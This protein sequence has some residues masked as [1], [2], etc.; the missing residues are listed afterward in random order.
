VR[1]SAPPVVFSAGWRRYSGTTRSLSVGFQRR[2]PLG[3]AQLTVGSYS[4]D[5]D[6]MGVH[7]DL[8]EHTIIIVL[9]TRGTD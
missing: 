8:H 1:I 4:G 5:K 9:Y 7:V 2:P 3:S 6:T